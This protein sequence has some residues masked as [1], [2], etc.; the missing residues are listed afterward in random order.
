A[1]L[2]SRPGEAIYNDANGLVEGNNPF[3]VV[4]LPEALR[5]AYLREV[6]ELQRRRGK[7][8]GGQIVFKGN[9]PADL[10]RNPLLGELLARPGG[11]AE[12]GPALAWLGEAI[13]IKDPTAATFRAQSGGNLLLIGQNEEGALGILSAA[14]VSLVA[15]RRP[16]DGSRIAVLDGTPE[17][18]P[19]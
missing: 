1:R 19:H 14:L 17:D 15:Q 18:S 9:S 7:P 2:L 12:R 3:Q 10:M 6:G 4:W 13:A 11:P 16:E 5:E 8:A